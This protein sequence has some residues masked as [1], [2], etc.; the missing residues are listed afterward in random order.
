MLWVG[1]LGPVGP[2]KVVAIM[3][4]EEG[5]DAVSP[6]IGNAVLAGMREYDR[7]RQDELVLVD[8]ALEIAEDVVATRNVVAE[9]WRVV[10]K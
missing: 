5:A 7:V 1:R 3:L 4:A 8:A 6:K 2:A 9:V 10:C